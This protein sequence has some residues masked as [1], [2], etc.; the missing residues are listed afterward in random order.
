MTSSLEASINGMN[1]SGFSL[2][3]IRS[4]GF[5]PGIF[6]NSLNSSSGFSHVDTPFPETETGVGTAETSNHIVAWVFFGLLSG[7]IYPETLGYKEAH[8]PK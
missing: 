2:I 1:K 8:W 4:S 5:L 3:G 7:S 6:R